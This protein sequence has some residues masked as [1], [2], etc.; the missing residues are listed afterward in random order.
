VFQDWKL[1]SL[2]LSIILL[3]IIVSCGIEMNGCAKSEFRDNILEPEE[4]MNLSLVL[5]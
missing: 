5:K 2:L 1:N 3:I 4:K